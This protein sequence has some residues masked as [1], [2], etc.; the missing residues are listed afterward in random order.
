MKAEAMARPVEVLMVEDNPGDIRLTQISFKS[1]KI[2]NNLNVVENGEDAMLYL[3]KEGR[4]SGAVMPDLVLLDL[5]LPKKDGR[6][7]LKEIKADEKLKH[8]PVVIM[9]SSDFDMDI[10]KSYQLQASCYITK[11][12]GFEEFMKILKSI[13]DF[14]LMIVQLPPREN[15]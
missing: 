11:P 8:L 14:W 1:F 15:G 13:D 4:F 9:T 7:V 3:R 12:A 10:L 5:N 6:T 2:K